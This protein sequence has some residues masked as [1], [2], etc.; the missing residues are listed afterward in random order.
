MGL[1]GSILLEPS[2]QGTV[3]PKLALCAVPVFVAGLLEDTGWRVPAVWRLA[4][5]VCSSVLA[6]GVL[7]T[8]L[9]RLGF[10]PVD[11]VFALFLPAMVGTVLVLTGAAHAFNLVDGLH[12]LCGFAGLI[13]AG[14]LA[15]IA[16]KTGQD[17]MAQVLWSV[18]ASVGG[19]L[20]VNFPRGLLFMGDAGAY[21]LGFVLACI[22]V[23]MLQFT[24]E[25]SPW[26]VVLVFF[27]PLADMVFAVA[28]RI[29]NRRSPLC[30]DRLHFHHILLR[31]VEILF[32][33]R[34]N[35]TLSNPV[36]TLI[37]LPFMAAPAILGVLVWNRNG[38]AFGL[39]VLSTSLFQITYRAVAA[40]A[41]R[42][43]FAVFGVTPQTG[44]RKA[45]RHKRV[46]RDK[47]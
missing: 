7:G 1:A 3:L 12:G 32:I 41:K 30:A 45:K 4:A 26:A 36:A 27:W 29:A 16:L 20:L 10:A 44:H 43:S 47:V 15:M 14:A 2:L 46:R 22:A 40:A 35:S 38:L 31:S 33:A 25:L 19:V 24:P 34:Q 5:S 9:T 18:M 11:A 28:R 21:V 17:P 6:I 42:R 8:V 13:T 37:L 23:K 39:V